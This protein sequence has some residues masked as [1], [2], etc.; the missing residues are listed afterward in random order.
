MRVPLKGNCQKRINLNPIRLETKNILFVDR[1][2]FCVQLHVKTNTLQQ[3]HTR[4][5]VNIEGHILLY[6]YNK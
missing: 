5:T 2:F 1:V 4:N 3:Q 6:L